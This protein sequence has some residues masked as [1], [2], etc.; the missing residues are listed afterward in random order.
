MSIFSEQA[1]FMEQGKQVTNG[2]ASQRQISL[3]AGLIEEESNEFL[4]SFFKKQNDVE[5]VKEAVDIIVVAAGFL[6][7]MLGTEGAEEAWQAVYV[8]NLTK[9]SGLIDTRV[10]GKILKSEEYK[11]TAKKALMEKLDKIYT[12]IYEK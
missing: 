2:L 10:D 6:V 7:S 5:S 12:G 1:C 11:K 8:S 4:E 9:V 3:Y